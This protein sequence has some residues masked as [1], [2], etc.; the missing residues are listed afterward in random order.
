MRQTR[1]TILVGAGTTL[2]KHAVG[3]QNQILIADLFSGSGLSWATFANPT[4][5]SF[6]STSS[7]PVVGAGAT[8]LATFNSTYET[9]RV[10]I[11]GGSGTSSRIQIQDS[12]PYSL[13]FSA[14]I[15]LTS[16]TQPKVGD[17]WFRINGQDVPQ[18]NTQT[19]IS[20]KDFQSVITINFVYTPR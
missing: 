7:Q 16:G 14:Q 19:T 11:I 6:Y 20:G 2:I 3:S 9:N 12:G 8:T 15:N 13:T 10:A 1:E 18:S 5:G 17:F 4:Y